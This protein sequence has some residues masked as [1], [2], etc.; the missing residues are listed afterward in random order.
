LE[1]IVHDG[2]PDWTG[3]TDVG[4][5]PIFCVQVIKM[6]RFI[7]P[8]VLIILSGLAFWGYWEWSHFTLDLTGINLDL[9]FTE[10]DFPSEVVKK[11]KK[12]AA[13]RDLIRKQYPGLYEAVSNAMFKKDPIGL[14]DKTNTD[15]YDLEAA[16]VCPR[17][18]NCSS[19]DDVKNV[20]F[21]IFTMNIFISNDDS[22]TIRNRSHYVGLGNKIWKIWVKARA[23]QKV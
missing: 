12:I 2:D 8:V 16:L 23:N 15:E 18:K 13:D 1:K 6:K 17:L 22:K 11:L 7:I 9:K 19:S 21:E 5:D 3:K 14:N 4:A 20:L 10:K